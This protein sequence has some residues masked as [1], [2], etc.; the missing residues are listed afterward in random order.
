MD[1]GT[2]GQDSVDSDVALA[3]GCFASIGRSRLADLLVGFGRTTPGIDVGVHE[4]PRAALLPALVAR[5]LDLVVMPARP[6]TDLPSQRL[7]RDRTMVAMAPGHPLATRAALAPADLQRETFLISRQA[8]AGEMHRFLAER[9]GPAAIANGIL[10]NTGLPRL[11][12][13][14]AAG[15]ELALVPGSWPAGDGIVLR[16]FAD[17]AADFTLVAY[18]RDRRPD[19]PLSWLIAALRSTADD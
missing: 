16:P 10:Y 5:E 12:D 19:P 11:L 9:I 6:L 17:D 4:M 1:S 8:Q 7:W 18:W 2:L 14:V 3:I 13:Q 15:R